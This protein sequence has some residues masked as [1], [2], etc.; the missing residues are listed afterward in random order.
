MNA[1]KVKI[2]EQCK[3][4]LLDRKEHL[5]SAIAELNAS[6]ENETKSSLGDKHET[7]RA[8]M[9]AEAEKLHRQRNELMDQIVLLQKTDLTR[10][11]KN[12]S[13]EHLVK[14]SNGLFFLCIPLGKIE[15]ENQ[16][17]FIISP[18]SPLGQ[19]LLGLKTGDSFTLNARNYTI[20]AI[21]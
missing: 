18:V 19:R 5:T 21:Y 2:L 14:T 9:Q 16:T 13:A 1:F 11:T 7:A 15:I 6:M 12:I 3:K 8:R 20:E 10:S 17:V 4:T